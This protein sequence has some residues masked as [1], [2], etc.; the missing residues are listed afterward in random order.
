M[1]STPLKNLETDIDCGI[2]LITTWNTLPHK[3]ILNLSRQ[4]PELVFSAEYCFDHRNNGT[5]H[6]RRYKNGAEI[7]DVLKPEYTI[8]AN[9]HNII[10][11]EKRIMG[12]CWNTLFDKA[13]M[14]FS[15][16]DIVKVDERG[17]KF[18]DFVSGITLTVEDDNYQ[19]QLSKSHS[20]IE[21]KCFEKEE[22]ITYKLVPVGTSNPF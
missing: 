6:I 9:D 11:D 7:D 8:K 19:M 17:N 20:D 4:N 1:K 12:S 2:V 21:I 14:I 5:L 22:V 10:E 18:I 15:H 3:E 13:I 16:I